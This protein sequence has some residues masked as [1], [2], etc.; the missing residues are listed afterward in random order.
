[1]KLIGSYRMPLA[2]FIFIG[3][4]FLK[5]APLI[6]TVAIFVAAA[7]YNRKT[8]QPLKNYRFWI[9]IVVL[10]VIVPIFTGEQDRSFLGLTYSS[11][12]LGKTLLMT[13]RAISVFILFQVITTDLNIEKIKPLFTK[14]GFNNFET[15]YTL[16][17]DIF[18]KIKS[19]LGAR[20]NLFK[21]DWKR[22]RSFESIIVFVTDVFN[23]FF[24]LTDTQLNPS[25][26]KYKVTPQEFVDGNK[27][28]ESKSL[29]VIVGDAEVG[30][31][32]W[33][34]EVIELLKRNGKSVDG[35]ISKKVVIAEEK[36]HHD[37][38]RIS[39]GEKHQ[40]TT[41][42]EIE[43]S[44]SIGKFNFYEE[45]IAWGNE[46]L[47]SINNSKIMII[48]EIGLLEFDNKGFLP[49]LNQLIKFHEGSLIITLRTSLQSRFDEFLIRQLD[50]IELWQRE[51]ITL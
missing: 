37:L 30:K 19:I 31:T 33:I 3:I 43:T 49:G 38:V 46:Q 10:V 17:N 35:L 26:S 4:I 51:Y 24:I 47:V 25:P 2:I 44:T 40:L 7:L 18:P 29:F 36:W 11:Q 23:D 28:D 13:F 14:I 50:E 8:I 15:L 16:S 20:Y 6:I 27:L 42:D 12:Q 48:D 22:S 41:M 5:Y 1:M 32:S 9:V 21:L 39:A 45:T 34:E